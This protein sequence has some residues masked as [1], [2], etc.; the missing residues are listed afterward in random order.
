VTEPT[1]SAAVVGTG[2]GCLTH[3][4]ALRAA[5]FEVRAL[6][7]R[8]PD[9]TA[10]RARRF[11]V[12]LASTSLAEALEPVD[13]V[14]VVTPP[15]TH[16]PITLEAL[17]AGKHVLCEKPFARDAAEARTMLEAA[18][19]AGVV[20]FVGTEFRWATGQELMR[21]VIAD[22][23]IGEP[24]LVT[25]LLQLPL[26]AS[27]DAEV[28]DWWSD[29]AQ[30]GGWLGAHAAHV[31]D[32]IR[33]TLG[34]FDGV[35][36]SLPNVAEHDWTAEDSYT[37]HFRLRSGAT[38]VLQASAGDWGPPVIVVR[39][40]GSEGTVWA[41]GDT[42]HLATERGTETISVPVDLT[43]LPPDPPPADLMV[44]AYDLMH[45]TGIDLDPYTRLAIAFRALIVG[46]EIPKDPP[47]PSFADGVAV[48]EVLDAIRASAAEKKWVSVRE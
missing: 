17:S 46:D 1:L 11:D 39:I 20:H 15:H 21:R 29:A 10:E 6:V 40:A 30:G 28:P 12:P 45:S 26:L 32:Q 9:K 47:V 43:P 37:V 27:P 23:A 5:G 8:D 41:E 42:V 25:Y 16:A 38:G 24:R 44:S 22:G 7:G 18:E 14:A 33:T 36:A 13:V 34:E 48:M 3:V 4:R 31:V 35:S 2:F 19:A